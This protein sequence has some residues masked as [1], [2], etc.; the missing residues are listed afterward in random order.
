MPDYHFLNNSV[1]TKVIWRSLIH[2]KFDTSEY[3]FVHVITLP[4][5]MQNSSLNQN[6]IVCSENEWLWKKAAIQW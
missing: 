1:K 3:E 5:K 2:K 4:H 6:Y